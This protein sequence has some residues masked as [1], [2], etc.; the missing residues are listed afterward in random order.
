MKVTESRLPNSEGISPESLL[1]E[2]VLLKIGK[3]K[4][5]NKSI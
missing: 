2:V 3:K 5:E 1:K 4:K